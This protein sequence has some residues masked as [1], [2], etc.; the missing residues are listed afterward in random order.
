LTRPYL[1]VYLIGS[2]SGNVTGNDDQ[3][4]GSLI[5]DYFHGG[6]LAFPQKTIDH[7]AVLAAHAPLYVSV[8]LE[9]PA[10]IGPIADLGATVI[11]EFGAGDRVV[12]D[13]I[14][15]RQPITGTLPFDI[16]SSMEAVE[17]SREDVPFDTD[18]PRFRAGFGLRQKE[19]ETGTVVRG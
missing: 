4:R 12:I 1:S 13:A 18:A 15:G 11:G 16:P 2:V 3:G 10:I 6:T 17:N 7:L 9:R 19:L 5:A 14:T 8:F